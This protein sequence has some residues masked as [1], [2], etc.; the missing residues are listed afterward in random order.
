MRRMR[1]RWLPISMLLLF[2][3]GAAEKGPTQPA[4]GVPLAS[5]SGS[6]GASASANPEVVVAPIVLAA[7]ARQT[8]AAGTAFTAPAGWTLQAQGARVSITAPEGDLRVAVVEAKGAGAGS[9]DG[10]D[11]AVRA[12]WASVHPGF[13]RPL[14]LA[15]PRPGRRGW[16]E[17]RIYDY[18]T[19][20][21]EKLYVLARAFRHGDAWTVLVIES[22]LATLE[23]RASQLRRIG[24]T[25][26]PPGWSRETF[27]GKAAH[28]LDAARLERIKASADKAREQ[29]GIPGEGLALV[30]NGKVVFEG[31]LGVKELGK[32]D[33]IGAN[34]TFLI[35]SN[36]KALT[37]LLLAKL[38]DEKKIAWDTPVKKLYPDFKLGD[39][40]TTDKVLVSHLICACTGMPRQ[41]MEW[42]FAF[43]KQTPKSEMELLGTM[44][45]TTKFGEA[46]QYSNSMA[47]AAGYVGA[48][49]LAPKKE[50]GQGYDEAM[51]SRVFGP[52]GMNDTTFDFAR[53]LKGDH[54]IGHALDVDGKPSRAVMELNRSVIPLRPA[55]GAWSSVHDVAKYVAMEL[56]KG[57]LPGGQRYVSEDALLARQK[58]NV[59]IG[60][61]ATYGMGLMVDTEFGVH[62][63]HHG[64]D[65]FGYHSDM[66]WIP[67]ANTGG[68]ILTNGDGYL[69]RKAF[70]RK[71]LEELY[72]GHPEADDDV[73]SAITEFR[74]QI[75]VERKRMALPA[76][77]ALVAKL[78]KRYRSAALG[79]VVVHADAKPGATFELGGWKSE[80]ATRKNDDGTVS[81][82]TVAAGGAEVAFVVAEREGKR[83]LVVRDMQHEYVFVEQP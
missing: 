64:G 75:A 58:P 35:A 49:V 72:D 40:A 27:A 2:A 31:G 71:V 46:F 4:A 33:K 60:E 42:L 63:V 12:A 3:C 18:E 15:Q 79:D 50:L 44:Q 29:A 56:A 25:L 20:P 37:T 47:A 59:S 43:Q 54:A 8:T 23:K 67:E 52:L 6:A 10:A 34:T 48:F 61:Y 76:D 77:P 1:T 17:Q 82:V 81:I 55:G 9:A 83:A 57:A 69:V 78:A 16:D 7:D 24:D 73:A 22:G 39:A 70:I 45:P 28:E 30:Q 38:V 36:T 26:V 80:I 32:P 53:A 21:N 11:A 62:V 41:D 65:L 5:S 14:R 66:F 19:S 51:Q 74:A 13:A 68:V